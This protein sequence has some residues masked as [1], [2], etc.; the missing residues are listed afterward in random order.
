MRD[1]THD[2]LEMAPIEPD[3][4]DDALMEKASE[5]KGRAGQTVRRALSATS[6]FALQAAMMIIAMF[7]M[8]A[9]GP[10]LIAWCEGASPL[11]PGQTKEL[12]REFRQ[13]S[14]SVIVSS[15]ATGL[16]QTV[17]ALLGYLI[18]GVPHPWFFAVLTFFMSFI[19]AIGAGGVCVVA[20]LFLLAQG[21][22]GMAIFLAAW[23]ILAVGLSDNLVKPLIAKS[24]MGMHGAVVFFSLVG[25]LLAFGTIGLLLGPLIVSFLLTLV[26]MR[27]RDRHAPAVL[28]PE[29]NE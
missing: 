4:L 17:A 14:V 6:Q 22:L 12:L 7:F 13:V 21:K 27:D 18:A 28:T 24:G 16:V 9:D 15:L 1:V 10:S 3:K 11:K 25:G 26:R 5:Q 23:G 2:L 20:A 29:T 19:P 8:L